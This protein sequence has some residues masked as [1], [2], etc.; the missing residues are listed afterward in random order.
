LER[1]Y[2]ILYRGENI[3]TVRVTCRGL[4][5]HFRC[6]CNLPEHDIFRLMV[7]SGTV[8]NS[9][10]ILIPTEGSFGLDTQISKKKIGEGELVFSLI[11]KEEKRTGT[12]VPIRAEEPF[13]YIS[14]LKQSFLAQKDGK[15]G[16][17]ININ[18]G[19]R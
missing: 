8:Q 10:G 12:F 3:G 17:F 18:A 9:L 15:D 5:Y 14:Q 16:I 7:S 19:V 2:G 6:R 4:Y 1:Q 11:P 13:A